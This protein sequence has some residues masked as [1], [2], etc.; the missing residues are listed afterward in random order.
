MKIFS[1]LTK[2]FHTLMRS[3]RHCYS[4]C[5][6]RIHCSIMWSKLSLTKRKTI[7]NVQSLKY[8][9]GWT[10]LVMRQ[11]RLKLNPLLQPCSILYT[12]NW[13]IVS[14][15]FGLSQGT[16]WYNRTAFLSGNKAQIFFP[17][18]LDFFNFLD[19]CD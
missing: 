16:I 4:N 14:R 3:T 2:V 12:K 18:F 13:E 5:Y 11:T 10:L 8:M 6:K 15:I 7:L 9:N 19:N 1:L 17:K